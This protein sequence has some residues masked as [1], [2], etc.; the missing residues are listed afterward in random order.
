[1]GPITTEF[2]LDM[3]VR[4]LRDTLSGPDLTSS[5]GLLNADTLRFTPFDAGV[6]FD[7]DANGMVNSN[8][9]DQLRSAVVSL[10][11]RD[12]EPF[13]IAVVDVA[14]TPAG[15][16]RSLADVTT[17]LASSSGSTPGQN[18]AYVFVTGVRN[19]TA[20]RSIPVTL[21]G[22]APLFDISGGSN[23]RDDTA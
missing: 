18:H 11:Q 7:Y 20:A 14:T 9:A 16:A 10:V 3:T 22:L 23:S 1:G 17:R 21:Y 2:F 5:G 19:L 6:D 4:Q 8:D 13:D 15:G 12:Y